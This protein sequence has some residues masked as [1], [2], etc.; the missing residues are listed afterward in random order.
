MLTSNLLLY[1]KYYL[2]EEKYS[3]P[4]LLSLTI[5]IGLCIPLWVWVLKKVGKKNGL[6]LFLCFSFFYCYSYFFSFFFSAC[7]IGIGP[8]MLIFLAFIFVQPGQVSFFFFLNFFSIT[9]FYFFQP[10][11]S[12]CILFVYITWMWCFLFYYLY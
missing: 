10:K 12:T 1:V 6:F 3:T 9:Y 7:F 11:G 5:S 4:I 2:G 8:T